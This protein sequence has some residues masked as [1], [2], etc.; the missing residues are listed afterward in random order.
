[1]FIHSLHRI[2]FRNAAAGLA[3]V[4]VP[5]LL[6]VLQALAILDFGAADSKAYE[7]FRL[8]RSKEVSKVS[9]AKPLSRA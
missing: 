9:S 1:L 3:V 8:N 2:E 5:A 6:P 7:L 4:C